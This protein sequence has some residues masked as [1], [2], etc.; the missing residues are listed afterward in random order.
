MAGTRICSIIGRKDAGK[1]T[2]A[3]ALA[4]EF[5]RRGRRVMTIKHS[6]HPTA[7]DVE[8][9]DSWRHFHEGKAERVVLA[10][11]DARYILERSPDDLDPVALAKRYCDGADIVLVEGFK[12]AP[13]P[14][15]DIEP[16]HYF[17]IQL[18]STPA[19]GTPLPKADFVIEGQMSFGLSAEKGKL[20]LLMAD[21]PLDR[22]G[23][24]NYQCDADWFDFLGWGTASQAEG[25]PAKAT[26]KEF[27]AIRKLGGRADTDDN[28]ADFEIGTPT[29]R[30]SN[31]TRAT[32]SGGCAAI[33]CARRSVS[34]SSASRATTRFTN[35]AATAA[36]T[37]NRSPASR[38]S[39]AR[40]SPTIRG[41]RTLRP[42]VGGSPIAVSGSPKSASSAATRI[43]QAAA[44]SKPPARTYPCSAFHQ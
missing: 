11:P 38:N 25:T 22:C 23:S 36:S 15:V 18:G 35:P 7:V 8:G 43:S 30:N 27:A 5:A 20:A 26:K 31:R 40:P 17:L 24:E 33:T 21:G 9:T 42:L 29:P 37:S 13:L 41:S 10:C 12:S 34:A 2:L 4:A 3:V 19:E 16:G 44:S 14:K 1:T 28:A 39:W 6:A 32:P